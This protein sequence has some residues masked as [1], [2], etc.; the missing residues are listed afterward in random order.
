MQN[1][2]RV[3]IIDDHLVTRQGI[4]SLLKNNKKIEIVAEGNAGNHV[5]E[6][7]ETHKPDVLIT[8][9]QMPAHENNPKGV[10]FEPISTLKKAIEQF[11]STAIIVFSQE[12][13]I[14]TIQSLAQI[15]VKGYL[16]KTDDFASTLDQVVEMVHAGKMYFSPEVQ[17]IIISAPRLKH[18]QHLTA[19]QMN[20]LRTIMRSP[21]ATRVE[22]AESLSISPSTLQKHINAIFAA[23]DV[24]NME[25]C[26]LKAMRMR[27]VDVKAVLG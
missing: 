26:F 4:I 18:N 27:L 25:S 3:V 2:I 16:L 24:P 12:H 11:E 21:A 20:V 22:L 10:L 1:L 13:D 19:Q 9:L 8:D 14:Q 5:F 6:L 23:L 17:E 7:L 15:G